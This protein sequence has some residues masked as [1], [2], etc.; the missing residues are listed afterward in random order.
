MEKMQ[1]KQG[2]FVPC[3]GKYV[4]RW[5][6]C[7]FV[8]CSSLCVSMAQTVSLNSRE[9]TLVKVIEELRRQTDYNFLF[10][11]ED[12]ARVATVTVNLKDVPLE[13]ALDAVLADKGL[14]YRV[15]N[16]TVIILK[17]PMQQIIE[18]RTVKGM[19]KDA[20]GEPIPGASVVVKGTSV[21]VATDIDGR[22]EI[23]VDDKLGLAFVVSFVGMKSKEVAVG[24]S[25][26]LN[27]V[28][29]SDM[30][31]L[32][33]VVVTGFQ[34]ISR[35]RATGAFDV[36]SSEQLSRPASDLSSRLV[37]TTAGVQ[38]NLDKDGNLVFEIRGQ[39]SLNKDNARPL[40]VVDGFPVE[41]EF[42]SINPNDV[43]SVTILKDAAAASIWGARS[44][45]GVIV[46]TTKSGKA[47]AKK[48]A[49][50]E[51]SAFAKVSPKIDLD[52]YNP[53]ATSAETVEYEQKGFATNFFGG[54]WSPLDDSY[55][56][57][58][59]RYSQVVVA[60]NEHRLGYL[61]ADGLSQILDKL[62]NQ[63][64][65]EQIRK[66]LLQIPLTHQYNVN[67][68][69]ASERMS[70]MLS[71]MYE[72]DRDGFKGNNKDKLMVNY[73]TNMKLFR[74]LDFDFSAMVQYNKIKNNGAASEI[75][76]LSPYDMLV[77]ENGVR[78]KLSGSFYTPILDR[79]VPTEAF[80]YA[81][82]TYNPITEMENRDL[83]VR[84]LNT[85]VQGGLTVRF[86]EGLT[87]DTKFQYEMY[88]TYNKNIYGEETINVRSMINRTSTWDKETDK[89][90]PNLPK[91]EI[92]TQSK[93]EV[94]T[95]NFRNQ[96]NFNRIFAD[97]H[98]VSV[99]VGTEISERVSEGAKY[100]TTYGYNNETL[101]VGIFPNGPTG[102]QNWMGSNQ[103]FY[104][105]N[106]YSYTTDRYFSLYAN[107]SYSLDE[108]YTVSGSVR[109]DASN[110][111]TDDPQYRYSP[112][113]SVGL[114]WQI[115]KER[116]MADIDWIDRLNIRATYGYN[117]NVDKTT[118]FRPLIDI[119]T[120]QNI[121]THAITS[122][123][124][125]FGN[126]TLRWEKTGTWNIGTDYS[127]WNGKL[128]GKLDIYNKNGKDLITAMTIP[129]VNGTN[130][131]KLNTARMVNRGL[132]LEVGT[133]MLLLASDIIW[134]G[135]L[136]F[137]YNK[138]KITNLYKATYGAYNL[139]SGG[140]S[141]YVEGH[142]ANTLWAY[143]YAGVVNDGTESN[144]N[145]LPAVY[146]LNR[147]VYDFSQW[148]SGDAREYMLDMGTKVA[149][150]TLGFSNSFKIYDFNFSFIITGKFGHKFRR[151]S[152]NY[153]SMSSG[154]ARPNKYY[155]EAL[156]AD[157]MK[158]VPIPLDKSEPSYYYWNSYYPYVDYLVERASHVRIQEINITYNMPA[159][160]L[161]KIGID[162]LQIYAQVNN[163]HTF[164]ANKYS[165]DPEYPMSGGIIRPRASYTL[166]LKF[167]F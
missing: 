70:N 155:K 28:L 26:V 55:M 90:T 86:L 24:T 159:P 60:L 39:T 94:R 9:Q 42:S 127:F 166:G 78:T 84:N 50:V 91:G 162:V 139:Y 38:G 104:Y 74:W 73:R 98:T 6:F 51:V 125:S 140:S 114:G 164:V 118:S 132:E 18:K 119:S 89:V 3:W 134:M 36:I 143:E 124:S 67:I 133:R 63:N 149:P 105:T 75:L 66:Y 12:L 40:I 7:L 47:G 35:E 57:A 144:P 62:R 101:S 14:T 30:K 48:G 121:Y 113:W 156:E 88:N 69:G 137:S 85:R 158:M 136:N 45:N 61:S 128:K 59:E 165:E 25:E 37:G 81:D 147:E 5:A 151:T 22:F 56:N 129:A 146:G 65:K 152:F 71:L 117:G 99:I 20:K 167:N 126:P 160:L 131:Q 53:L 150:Y 145:W 141:A 95:C 32:D 16:G 110:L 17:S 82:W 109:T 102:T 10:N 79:W 112:F 77:D 34:T 11:T 46:V 163:L 2:T 153:P 52:Y 123:I 83:G 107:A 49:T 120:T 148:V 87:F 58:E 97:R 106:S 8:C 15:E 44:A 161:S 31:A 27:V 43:E 33:E 13:Q 1:L 54:P 92:L 23:R 68:S 72:S 130:S 115:G 96:L 41:G 100:P 64:N 116:F 19:V 142:N 154:F 122:S 29:E 76:S 93:S 135:S 157:P 4:G 138:N 108:K 21:G 80:P 103:S 111:I